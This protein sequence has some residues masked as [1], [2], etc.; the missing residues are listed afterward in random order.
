MKNELKEFNIPV[1]FLFEGLF[2]IKA[3]NLD[4]AIDIVD[5]SCG[6]T[7]SNGVVTS[8]SEDIV[9]WYF[10][11]HPDKTIVRPLD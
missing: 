3:R 2:K 7:I 6:M 5:H 1:K 8:A 4:E 11:C 9:D 10:P